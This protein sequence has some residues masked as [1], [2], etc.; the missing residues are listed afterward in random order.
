MYYSNSYCTKK[1][2][3]QVFSL[4]PFYRVSFDLSCGIF[5]YFLRTVWFLM[6]IFTYIFHNALM[7]LPFAW[8]Y[9]WRVFFFCGGGGVGGGQED[10]FSVLFSISWEK[11][12]TFH[13]IL[14]KYSWYYSGNHTK[15]N[16]ACCLYFAG[17]FC[18]ITLLHII[19]SSPCHE[20]PQ[21]L[22][23]CFAQTFWSARK[24]ICILYICILFKRSV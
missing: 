16:K 22:T 24:Y 12:D 6:K 19:P 10:T 9:F 5:V 8:C 11:F 1:N 21:K 17:L 15:K 7:V 2:S 3:Q 4:R 13:E 20:K 23:W 14:Q 18:Y